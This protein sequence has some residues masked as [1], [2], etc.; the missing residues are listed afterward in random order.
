MYLKN[1]LNTSNCN[2]TWYNQDKARE[3][4]TFV[5]DHFKKEKHKLQQVTK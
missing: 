5:H 1:V 3:L 4:R 2:K